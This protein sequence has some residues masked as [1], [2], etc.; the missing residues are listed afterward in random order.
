MIKVL[1]NGA[2]GGIGSAT[3][4]LLKYFGADVTAVCNTKNIE[5]VKSRTSVPHEIGIETSQRGT[6]RNREGCTAIDGEILYRWIGCEIY[7]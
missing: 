6:S 2:S 7:Y 3:V 1:V 4:Q 5:L